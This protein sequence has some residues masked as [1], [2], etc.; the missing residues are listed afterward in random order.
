R[1]QPRKRELENRVTVRLGVSDQ[2]LDL[3]EILFGQ[4]A[5]VA[6][7]FRDARALGNGFSL[8]ILAGEQSALKRKERKERDAFALRLAENFRFRLPVKQ[9]VFVLHTRETHRSESRPF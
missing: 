4:H 3:I 2:P 7:V 5:S 6:V 8:A 1:Q 9:A